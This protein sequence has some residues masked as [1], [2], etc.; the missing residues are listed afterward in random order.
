MNSLLVGVNRRQ[1]IVNDEN[2]RVSSKN[3]SK[4]V[5]RWEGSEVKNPNGGPTSLV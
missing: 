1:K 2:S 3:V 4:I 5:D